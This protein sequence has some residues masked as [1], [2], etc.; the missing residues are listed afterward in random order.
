MQQKTKPASVVVAVM[1]LPCFAILLAIVVMLTGVAWVL[2][3]MICVVPTCVSTVTARWIRCFEKSRSKWNTRNC[4]TT[5]S[6]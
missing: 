1:A 5:T 3:F 6:Y 4:G 2:R